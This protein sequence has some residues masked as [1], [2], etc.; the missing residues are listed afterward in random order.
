VDKRPSKA[1]LTKM[2]ESCSLPIPEN[3]DLAES[4]EVFKKMN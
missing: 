2:K 3:S 4:P 1:L